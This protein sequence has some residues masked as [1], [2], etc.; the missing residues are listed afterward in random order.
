MPDNLFQDGTASL[1]ILNSP[2]TILFGCQAD[3]RLQGG[4]LP[5]LAGVLAVAAGDS[6]GNPADPTTDESMKGIES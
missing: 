5:G 1:S 2:S 6:R 4:K 3:I